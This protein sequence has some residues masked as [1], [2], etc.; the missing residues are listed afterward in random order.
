VDALRRAAIA[1]CAFALAAPGAVR[2]DT[3]LRFE[4]TGSKRI[5][6]SSPEGTDVATVSISGESYDDAELALV[7]RDSAGKEL[8]RD[9]HPYRERGDSSC[10][11]GTATRHV[12]EELEEIGKYRAQSLPDPLPAGPDLWGNR[13]VLDSERYERLRAANLVV[14]THFTGSEDIEWV[15][16]DPAIGKAVVAVEVN[17]G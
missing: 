17:G 7:I 2:L 11:W 12:E 10:A 5:A 9:A 13:V 1:L 3:N 4:V 15:V 6:F 8:Y 16:F 14:I